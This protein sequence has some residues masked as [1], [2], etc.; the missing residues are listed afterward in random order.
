MNNKVIKTIF[1]LTLVAC[2]A[3]CGTDAKPQQTETKEPENVAEEKIVDGIGRE[4]PKIDNIEKISITCN[5]GA[6]QELSVLQQNGKV[7]SQ[8]SIKPF[9]MLSKIYDNLNNTED[10]G[11][12]NDVNL[13]GLL[14][15]K[16]D[17]VFVGNHTQKTNE[18]IE[19][20][21]LPTFNLYCGMAG[22]DTLQ[23]EFKNVGMMLGVEQDAD[24]LRDYW[25]EKMTYVQDMLKDIPE[26]ERKTVYYTGDD[27]TAAN[28][29]EWGK[30][31]I[32]LINADFAMKDIPAG[33][34]VSVEQVLNINPDVIIKQKND[35]GVS[36]ILNDERITKLKAV[37][38][39]DV[40]QCPI[41]AFWW[42]RP[43]PESPL[44]FMWLAKT[45]YPEYT[46]DIDLIKETKDFFKEFYHYDL[47][48]E[49]YNSFF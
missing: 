7:I 39:K 41:G 27:I 49:E 9:K 32:N 30:S 16:P 19:K 45:V 26:N 42:D 47:T 28:N 6:I 40:Y 14:A 10:V 17:I 5:G 21:G 36:T 11:S 13:E 18:Q 8:P 22:I 4:T 25:Q 46:K 1:A 15:L 33:S 12:F 35:K 37:E 38:S 34:E 29:G 23:D 2:L 44:G 48:D 43:S 20:L 3:A 24:K 31:F